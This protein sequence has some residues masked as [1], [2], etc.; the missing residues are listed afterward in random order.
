MQRQIILSLRD[1]VPARNLPS[2]RV[3]ET[4]GNS[5]DCHGQEPRHYLELR[6]SSLCARRRVFNSEAILS[7]RRDCTF[8][9]A[10]DAREKV[11]LYVTSHRRQRVVTFGFLP[12]SFGSPPSTMLIFHSSVARM[13]GN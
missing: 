4:D 5:N 12:L 13:Q 11:V 9:I 1:G 8:A 3:A 10:V 2:S 6:A 7:C